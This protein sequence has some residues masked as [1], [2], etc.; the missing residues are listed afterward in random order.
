ML[1]VLTVTEQS[2]GLS[3]SRT[4]RLMVSRYGHLRCA[5]GGAAGGAVG[6]AVGAVD[7]A[8]ALRFVGRALADTEAVSVAGAGIETA[9]FFSLGGEGACAFGLVGFTLGWIFL[10][11]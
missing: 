10:V 11:R 8:S 3:K 5:T 7:S 4:W 1:S 2:F 6:G 9:T